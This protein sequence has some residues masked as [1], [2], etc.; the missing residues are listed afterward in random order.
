MKVEQ[1]DGS[2]AEDSYGDWKVEGTDYTWNVAHRGSHSPGLSNFDMATTLNGQAF[3]A[4]SASDPGGAACAVSAGSGSWFDTNC[5]GFALLGTAP[6]YGPLTGL[7]SAELL[8]QETHCTSFGGNG[9][10]S[11][12]ES[13]YI[14]TAEGFCFSCPAAAACDL[15]NCANG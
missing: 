11:A 12:C 4:Q 15:S 1:S 3:Q 14:L 9:L 7:L 2:G 8:A 5:D 13:G 10:C 6:F